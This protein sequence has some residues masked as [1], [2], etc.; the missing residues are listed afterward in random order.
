MGAGGRSLAPGAPLSPRLSGQRRAADTDALPYPD[1]C[2]LQFARAPLP[3][4]VK[5][6]LI[7]ALGARRATLAHRGMTRAVFAGIRDARLCA[8]ELWVD[9]P[10]PFFAR[11]APVRRQ[12]GRSLGER[13][14]Y[15]ARDG[16]G[17]W[18]CVLLVGSDCLELDPRYLRRALDGLAAGADAVLGLAE[19]GGYVLLGLRRFDQRLFRGMPWSSPALARATRRRLAGMRWR[20]DTLPARRDVDTVDDLAALPTPLRRQLRR[21]AVGARGAVSVRLPRAPRA[22]RERSPRRP[23]SSR[24]TETCPFPAAGT[25]GSRDPSCSSAAR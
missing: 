12:R 5:T 16:L 11:F 22:P 24:R 20:V 15:A 6:R 7:P 13:M 4:K 25:S 23:R 18:R 10:H 9:R 19:D 17:R 21:P 2:V 3:G 8:H 14:A 1:S